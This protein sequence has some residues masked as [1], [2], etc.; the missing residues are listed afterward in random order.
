[1]HLRGIVKAAARGNFQIGYVSGERGIGKSSLA[2]FVRHLAQR[3]SKAL[4][5]HVFL[6]GTE[7]LKGMLL[8]TFKRL[9]KESVDKSWHRQIL[10]FLKIESAV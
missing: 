5:C 3:E 10:D 2:S 9:L 1:M 6:G 4:G 7:N 8:M